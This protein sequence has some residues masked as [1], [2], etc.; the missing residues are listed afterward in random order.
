M[1]YKSEAVETA[2]SALELKM[3]KDGKHLIKTESIITFVSQLIDLSDKVQEREELLE[4]GI[5]QVVQ[6]RLYARG[7]FSV[8]TGYFVNIAECEN[9]AYLQMIIDGK[10]S[11]I[12]GKIKARNRIKELVQWEGQMRFIPDNENRLNIIE[13]KPLDELME[14]LEADA[15]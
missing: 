1:Q 14:D 12:E 13:Y 3:R 5:K 6:S 15:V 2:I 10:D 8:M 11:V 4:V 9:V 7:Y